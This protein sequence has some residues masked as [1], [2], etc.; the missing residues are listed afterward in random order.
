MI[1]RIISVKEMPLSLLSDT[2]PGLQQPLLSH[3]K[4]TAKPVTRRRRSKCKG[5]TERMILT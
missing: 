5:K 3:S 2:S 4:T 1:I